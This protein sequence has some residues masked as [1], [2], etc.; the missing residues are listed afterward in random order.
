MSNCNCFYFTKLWV[1]SGNF[2]PVIYTKPLF[3]SVSCEIIF[4]KFFLPCILFSPSSLG[5][6]PLSAFDPSPEDV[7][8]LSPST[9]MLS[10][11]FWTC[12]LVKLHYKYFIK[13]KYNLLVCIS[14]PKENIK[15]HLALFIVSFVITFCTNWLHWSIVIF[16]SILSCITHWL[17][18][19][20]V[21]L[22]TI[23][24]IHLI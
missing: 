2:F 19:L 18:L 23:A 16:S 5:P 4:V 15:M 12:N 22:S 17:I 24:A 14:I 7:L 3:N 13:E 8:W 10:R 6:R 20:T 21:Y 11:Y 9:F 1:Q